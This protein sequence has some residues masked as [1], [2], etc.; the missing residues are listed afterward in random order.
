VIQATG[1][2]SI[3]DDVFAHDNGGAGGPDR[4]LQ[5]TIRFS[6]KLAA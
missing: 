5:P 2:A 1:R 3:S 6:A 4:S